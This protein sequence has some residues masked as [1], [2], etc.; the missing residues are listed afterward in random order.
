[1]GRRPVAVERNAGP[2]LSGQ[3]IGLWIARVGG[4][5]RKLRGYSLLELVVVVAILAVLAAIAVP[6]FGDSA[7]RQRVE[8]AAWR[9]T[10]DLELARQRARL[11]GTSQTVE[12]NTATA[13]YR[14]PGI[15]DP[16][17]PSSPY[18]VRLG[19]E[20]YQV[21]LV[22]ASFGGD[23]DVKFDGWGQPDDAGS[24]VVGRG[25]FAATV[26]LSGDGQVL[27]GET[28]GNAVEPVAQETAEVVN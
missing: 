15:A 10:H 21:R 4:A 28:V 20:P 7:A 8:A 26:T 24:V 9:V 11:E 5:G 12:F 18:E 22:S 2:M 25:R 16:D 19:E 23:G 17:A 13:S 6:R 1:M 27:I 3:R 14:L